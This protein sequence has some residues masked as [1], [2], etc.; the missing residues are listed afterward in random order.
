MNGN[1][2][3]LISVYKICERFHYISVTGTYHN[4]CANELSLGVTDFFVST[5]NTFVIEENKSTT[6]ADCSDH[7]WNLVRLVG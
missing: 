4:Q 6:I 1:E 2:K 7:K 5:K 3:G